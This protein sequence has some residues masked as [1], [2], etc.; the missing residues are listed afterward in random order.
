LRILLI[1]DVPGWIIDYN[2]RELIK[3]NPDFEFRLEYNGFSIQELER[4][5][6]QFSLVHFMSWGEVHRVLPIAPNLNNLALTVRSHRYTPEVREFAGHCAGVL[7]V[8]QRLCQDFRDY[9]A[10]WM[11]NGIDME[12]FK[13]VRPFTVGYAG[14]DN[15]YKGVD[16]IRAA[17]AQLGVRL[18]VAPGDRSKHEMVDFY[19]AIDC[20]VCAS[21]AEGFSTP[22][23]EALA[24]NVPVVTVDA[25][26]PSNLNVIKVERSI[27]GLARGI[28]LLSGR[29]KIEADYGWETIAERQ[30]EWWI[31]L[32]AR[33]EG[34]ERTT[35]QPER[36]DRRYD[37]GSSRLAH[38]PGH[39][40]AAPVEGGPEGERR[41][42][43]QGQKD[44][45]SQERR[46]S[47]HL[48]AHS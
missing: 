23:M 48:W 16:L 34:S 13:P 28:E 6:D 12:L 42:E 30:R 2:C 1:A 45:Q 41:I 5:A 38:H 32:A 37:Q 11:P 20:Y 36:S 29:S 22:V 21:V 4:T 17:C 24:M 7:A 44:R 3:R 27:E 33:I 31:N 39:D 46:S 8:N 9:S 43:D 47:H 10:E 18:E 25:G 19:K 26:V 35:I 15:G 40:L 14:K